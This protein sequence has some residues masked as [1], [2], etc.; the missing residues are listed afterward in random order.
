MI[1]QNRMEA[2]KELAKQLASYQDSKDA[3]A[4]GLARG[5]VVVAVALARALNISLDVIVVRK[6]GAPDNPELALG[7][8]AEKGRGAFNDELIALLGVSKEY[9]KKETERQREIVKMRKELY[10]QGRKNQDFTGKTVLLVD[11]GIATGASMK[12]AI[13]S[14]K[15]Q[16]AGK[17]VVAT[18]VAPPEARQAIALLVDEVVCL[19]EP[20][21]FPAVGAFYKEFGQVSDEEIINLIRT[22]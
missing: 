10:L 16:N 14:V 7:A 19:S 11:D 22:K 13:E 5:G 15:E 4:V 20:S 2:G 21:R 9:I 12:V 1:F 6:I 17:I 18:P 3:I 8:I